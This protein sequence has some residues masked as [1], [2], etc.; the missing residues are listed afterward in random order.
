VQE[1][2]HCHAFDDFALEREAVNLPD[3]RIV[4]V[5]ALG[6]NSW[7]Y[8]LSHRRDLGLDHAGK[9]LDKQRKTAHPFVAPCRTLR[10]RV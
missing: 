2:F 8:W 1:N 6:A 5:L 7:A 10:S 4:L 9:Y 3:Y